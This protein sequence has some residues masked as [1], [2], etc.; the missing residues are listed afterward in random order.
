MWK[1][2]FSLATS[3]VEIDKPLTHAILSNPKH[4]IVKTLV[5]IYSLDSFVFYEMNKTSRDKDTSKI[6]YYGAFASALGYI[7]HCGNKKDSKL[8]NEFTVYRGL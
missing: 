6:K 1:K 3:N 5:Y 2:I 7:I 4:V 8:E